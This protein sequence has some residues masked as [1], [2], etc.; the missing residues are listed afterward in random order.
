VT[1]WVVGVVLFQGEDTCVALSGGSA[2]C[3]R[4]V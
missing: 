3:G 2:A 4:Q 1:E